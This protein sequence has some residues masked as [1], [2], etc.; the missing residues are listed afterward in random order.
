MA[1]PEISCVYMPLTLLPGLRVSVCAPDAS[2]RAVFVICSWG[3]WPMRYF[4][5]LSFL[6]YKVSETQHILSNA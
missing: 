3:E 6:Q 5:P 4:H 2:S 1:R